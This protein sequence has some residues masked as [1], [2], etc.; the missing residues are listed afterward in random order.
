M[1]QDGVSRLQHRIDDAIDQ[2]KNVPSSDLDYFVSRQRSMLAVWCEE[3]IKILDELGSVQSQQSQVARVEAGPGRVHDNG[4]EESETRVPVAVGGG[5]AMLSGSS[6]FTHR[7]EDMRSVK[8]NSE[9][10]SMSK[11]VAMGGVPALGRMVLPLQPEQPIKEAN[12]N[13]NNISNEENA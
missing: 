4:T 10:V 5:Q 7:D 8:C 13:E 12:N 9:M 6:S 11:I 3:E 1:L 2:L